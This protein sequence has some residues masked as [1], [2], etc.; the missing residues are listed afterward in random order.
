MPVTGERLKKLNDIMTFHG[1]DTDS[2]ERS[3]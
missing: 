1:T 3:P 2:Q